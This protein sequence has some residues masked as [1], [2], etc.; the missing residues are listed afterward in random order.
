MAQRAATGVPIH[1][2]GGRAFLGPSSQ[3]FQRP[4]PPLVDSSKL[5]KPDNH[6]VEAMDHQLMD[7]LIA[8]A[9]RAGYRP[10]GSP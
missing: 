9:S 1:I 2:R 6:V 10:C 8:F 4:S 7:L 5:V 3:D